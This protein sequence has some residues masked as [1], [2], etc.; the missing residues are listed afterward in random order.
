MNISSR[1]HYNKV[2]NA[3][4]EKTTSSLNGQQLSRV[5]INAGYIRAYDPSCPLVGWSVCNN[6]LQVTILCSYQSTSQIVEVIF[7]CLISF[8]QK[9]KL[10]AWLDCLKAR[11]FQRTDRRAADK[12]KHSDGSFARFCQITNLVTKLQH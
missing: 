2:Y 10:S 6:F 5:S 11:W 9:D 7:T 1:D 8:V 12:V 3:K 4:I